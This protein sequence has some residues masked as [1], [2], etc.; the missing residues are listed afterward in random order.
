MKTTIRR[1]LTLSTVAG[2]VAL[3]GATLTATPA[4]AGLGERIERHIERHERLHRRVARH[5]RRHV[6]HVDRDIRHDARHRSDRGR[7]ERRR[8]RFDVPLRI[9]RGH[10][11]FYRP[12]FRG[13]RWYGPHHHR[14]AVY[15]FPVWDGA[16]WVERP[17]VY[18]DGAL[19]IER[20]IGPPR[21]RLHVH[22]DF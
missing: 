22:I 8:E 18:C 5:V 11:D 20:P 12:Y 17:H 2:L 1:I 9:G 21:P 14:H 10:V 3:G 16:R 4:R 6:E 13:T 19:W 7:F 15:L